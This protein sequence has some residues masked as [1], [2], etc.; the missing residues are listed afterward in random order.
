VHWPF[1][2]ILAPPSPLALTMLRLEGDFEHYQDLGLRSRQWFDNKTDTSEGELSLHCVHVGAACL[3]SQIPW[4]S[5]FN[6]HTPPWSRWPGTIGAWIEAQ[7]QSEEKHQL[8]CH[9]NVSYV[10]GRKQYS[11]HFEPK[12]KIE[13]PKSALPVAVTFGLR[14]RN[15]R[16][17]EPSYY[18]LGQPTAPKRNG[19]AWML[20]QRNNDLELAD[21][22]SNLG[23]AGVRLR[24]W[25]ISQHNPELLV[26]G[27][28]QA[29]SLEDLEMLRNAV[30]NRLTKTSNA[31][32]K[33]RL[34]VVGT[35]KFKRKGKRESLEE[36]ISRL[37]QSTIGQR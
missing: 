6:G 23:L 10:Q 17:A 14:L 29:G 12:Q 37:Q 20:S 28:N 5:L 31:S 15:S 34:P 3:W 30:N 36:R 2:D 18:R 35:E 19:A 13:L 21:I 7:C 32:L 1:E 27:S 25:Q 9:L 11:H 26:Q 22:L 24:Q 16:S 4:T 8:G 33:L